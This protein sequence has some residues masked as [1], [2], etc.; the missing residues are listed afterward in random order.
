MN[1]ER[2]LYMGLLGQPG[3][4][5]LGAHAI[6]VARSG[7][8]TLQMGP[9]ATHHGDWA[10]VP[11]YVP[12]H[13]SSHDKVIF[14]LLIEPESI[15]A[16]SLAQ[17]ALVDDGC[18]LDLVLRLRALYAQGP[19]GV[20]LPALSNHAFDLLVWGQALPAR[21]LEPRVGQV[22]AL[23]QAD[24]AFSQSAAACAAICKV[25]TSRFM[26]LFKSEVGYSFRHVRTWRRARSLLALVK[27]QD[28]LTTIAQDL[29]Y[30]DASYF[31]NAI[32]QTSGLRPKDIMAGARRVK[33]LQPR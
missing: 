12:H 9:D 33:V 13:I 1:P 26:H 6:Y 21:N 19:T 30:S 17:A 18:L 24:P 2:V 22:M 8:V 29:G 3:E 32:R 7:S 31:S 27:S 14:C 16:D 4:R 20:T 23:M 10:L 28:S 15:R 11:P 25:S 5:V